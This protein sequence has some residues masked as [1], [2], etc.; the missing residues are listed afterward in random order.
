MNLHK[1]SGSGVS[2]DVK[3]QIAKYSVALQSQ[4]V[5]I[6][7]II[8]FLKETDYSPARSTLLNLM[9][10]TKRGEHMLSNDKASGHP[11]ALS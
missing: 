9:S 7:T 3:E 5:A 10:K 2:S 1:Y 11:S 6:S 8:D 4:G